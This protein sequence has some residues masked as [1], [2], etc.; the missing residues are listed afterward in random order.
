[1]KETNE[2]V[3]VTYEFI[4]YNGLTTGKLTEWKPFVISTEAWDYAVSKG[5]DWDVTDLKNFKE[6]FPEINLV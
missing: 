1:M 5:N 3:L 6:W 2:T 4:A